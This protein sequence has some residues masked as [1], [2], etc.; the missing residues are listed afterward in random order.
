[1]NTKKN[2][3]SFFKSEIKFWNYVVRN[4]LK[5]DIFFDLLR[6]VVL[7]REAYLRSEQQE[8]GLPFK[9]NIFF[10]T[11]VRITKA[12]QTINCLVTKF[13]SCFLKFYHFLR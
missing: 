10:S 7:L 11:S 12:H 4:D 5:Y 2:R 13:L 8:E 9:F 6:L 3:P 1:M